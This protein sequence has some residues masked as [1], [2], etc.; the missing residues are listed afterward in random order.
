MQLWYESRHPLLSNYV[1]ASA[2]LAIGLPFSAGVVHAQGWTKSEECLEAILSMAG[3][4]A[5][6]V[7][8]DVHEYR[9]AQRLPVPSKD[10]AERC[11]K[12]HLS[13]GTISLASYLAGYMVGKLF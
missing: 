3:G 12:S 2:I 1:K 4:Q 9:H 6:L 8:A 11:H 7:P 13:M 10:H 5:C